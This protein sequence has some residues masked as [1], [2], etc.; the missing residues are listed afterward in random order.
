MCT[1]IPASYRKHLNHLRNTRNS[2]G[3]SDSKHYWAHAAHK[4]GMVDTEEGI[5]ITEG[6]KAEGEKMGNF[7]APSAAEA[8]HEAAEKPPPV[9]LLVKPDDLSKTNMFFYTLLLQTQLVHLQKSELVAKRRTLP[10][11]LEG[12]GCRHCCATGRYGF[13]RRFPLRRR[14]LPEEVMDMYNHMRRCTLC[15]NQ[16]KELLEK[17]HAEHESEKANQGPGTKDGRGKDPHKE[18]F[19]IMWRRLGRTQD[20]KT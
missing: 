8:T 13:S 2:Q 19:D 7:G 5:Q 17:L 14:S 4:I 10:Q 18:F 9:T 6:S 15:P 3:A 16:V 12:I 11:G 1:A 20:I